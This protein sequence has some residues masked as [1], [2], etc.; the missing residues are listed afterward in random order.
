MVHNSKSFY[1][2]LEIFSNIDASMANL[3]AV[4]ADQIK[5]NLTFAKNKHSG[6]LVKMV[7]TDFNL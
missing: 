5:L 3:I 1:I 6:T 2:S 7:R 4:A